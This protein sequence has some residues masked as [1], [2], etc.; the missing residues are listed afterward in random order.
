MA[1]SKHYDECYFVDYDSYDDLNLYEVGCQVCAPNYNFGPII[2]SNYVLHYIIN[3]CG[4]LYLNGQHF[5][6]TSKQ[7]FI[8]PPHIP[9][10]YEADTDDP[11][12]YIWLHFNG[13]KA[14]DLL[15]H[16][17]ITRDFPIFVPK[18][19][20]DRLETCVKEILHHNDEEF[21]CIG[22]LYRMFQIMIDTSTRKPAQ[23]K[24]DNQLDY[25]RN[26]INYIKK[27][28][29]EPVRVQDIAEYCGLDRSYL[30][31][32]FKNATN[33]TPQEYLIYTR[34][35]KAKQLLKQ[36]ELSIQNIAYSVG[37]PDPFAFSKIFKK[38]TGISPSTY[39]EQHL[40]FTEKK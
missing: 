21:Y 24:T 8:T 32:L 18:N 9:V 25:I 19:N 3:G 7:A 20:D 11:W 23:L 22:N 34:M 4:V 33:Y 29:P 6:I 40:S 14:L 10:Y 30:C 1:I 13:Q 36:N 12:N 31:K 17:G 37:Y 28:Y 15:H 26:V 5:K 35:N 39:R 2:R 27:K 16:A 38:E